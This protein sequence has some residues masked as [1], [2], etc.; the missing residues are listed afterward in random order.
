MFPAA[1]IRALTWDKRSLVCTSTSS[2]VIALQAR[3][4]NGEDKGVK[5]KVTW[6]F[7]K[8]LFD[9]PLPFS[10]KITSIVI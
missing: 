10:Q 3:L 8:L 6:K 1:R 2:T 5:K 7:F 4:V 9:G